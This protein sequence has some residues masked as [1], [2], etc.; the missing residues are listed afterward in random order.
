MQIDAVAAAGQQALWTSLLIGGPLLLLLLLIGLAVS[1]LQALTQVQEP[2]LAF[3]PKM[4]ALGVA[5]L[6]GAPAAAGIMR[7]FALQLFD[8]IVTV[9]GMR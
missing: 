3:V 7:G 2:S 1:V 5:L 9:G 8:G 6:L 4:V